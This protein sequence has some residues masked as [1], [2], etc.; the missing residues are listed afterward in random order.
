VTVT[1]YDPMGVEDFVVTVSPDVP[2]PNG[3]N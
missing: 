2:D 3:S 1:V